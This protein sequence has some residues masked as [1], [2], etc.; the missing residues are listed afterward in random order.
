MWQFDCGNFANGNN[1][2]RIGDCGLAYDKK[3]DDDDDQDDDQEERIVGGEQVTANRYPWLVELLIVVP[4]FFKPKKMHCAATIIKNQFLLSAAHCFY[5]KYFAMVAWRI[6]AQS[7]SFLPYFIFSQASHIHPCHDRL[8]LLGYWIVPEDWSWNCDTSRSD[9]YTSP[10]WSSH[11]G[12]Y[13]VSYVQESSIDPACVC[14]RLEGMGGR[15]ESRLEA[16]KRY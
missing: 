13:T 6:N 5:Y 11:Y 3:T 9:L 7:Y 2:N 10:I 14:L 15:Q 16:L 12:K 1:K 8:P 4:D